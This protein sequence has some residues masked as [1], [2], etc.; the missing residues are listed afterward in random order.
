MAAGVVEAQLPRDAAALLAGAHADV[1]AV[2]LLRAADRA[3]A[4][5][6]LALGR[7]GALLGAAGGLAWGIMMEGE[8]AGLLRIGCVGL[9][10]AGV[11]GLKLL[12]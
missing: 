5:V 2:P 1:R 7:L 8:P 9:I 3:D 4:C 6:L 12:S 10:L 11:A